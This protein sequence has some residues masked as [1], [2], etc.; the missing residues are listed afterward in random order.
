VKTLKK[1]TK[2][3]LFIFG[4]LF[5]IFGCSD[6]EKPNISGTSLNLD[7]SN[8]ILEEK[9]VIEITNSLKVLNESRVNQRIDPKLF[10]EAVKQT[11]DPLVK[12]GRV[13]HAKIVNALEISGGTS[14]LSASEMKMIY[15]LDDTHLAELSFLM[16]Y[17]NNSSNNITTNDR[18]VA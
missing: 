17:A 8:E 14:N 5:M 11:L 10:E 12:N 16:S 18:I 15:E 9:I 6:L 2:A 3:L 4:C 1:C 7:L 13:L